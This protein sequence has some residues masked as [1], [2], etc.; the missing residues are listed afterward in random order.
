MLPN[1]ARQS[2]C[3]APCRPALRRV[4]LGAMDLRPAWATR[5]GRQ[6]YT[7]SKTLSQILRGGMRRMLRKVNLSDRSKTTLKPNFKR[8]DGEMRWKKTE[9]RG[10]G[11]IWTGK[12]RH[13]QSPTQ[14]NNVPG[15][16]HHSPTHS[17]TVSKSQSLGQRSALKCSAFMGHYVKTRSV[18]RRNA[19]GN[20]Y[21][22]KWPLPHYECG[23][24]CKC[25][26]QEHLTRVKVSKSVPMGILNISAQIELDSYSC[27][28]HVLCTMEGLPLLFKYLFLCP[29]IIPG[30][31]IAMLIPR[32]SC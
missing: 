17:I 26:S 12:N 14:S 9:L 13:N 7:H 20:A 32:I 24:A 5:W 15:G 19:M 2:K 1:A 23:P 31:G 8:N 16:H 11:L 27:R 28:S 6:R 3:L 4:K 29:H 18:Q 21:V 22:H 30:H 10:T 25:L